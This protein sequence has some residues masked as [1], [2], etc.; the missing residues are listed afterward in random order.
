VTWLLRGR[1]RIH[2]TTVGPRLRGR[3]IAPVAH[4]MKLRKCVNEVVRRGR[5][6]WLDASE[7]AALAAT[8]G[9]ASTV[10]AIRDMSLR[11]IHHVLM[12]GLM[13]AGDLPPDDESRSSR[14]LAVW[15][16]SSMDWCARVDRA[17]PNSDALGDS[18]V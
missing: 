2:L 12:H 3:L 6:D 15:G 7:I 1:A 13:Q 11:I 14:A 8:V 18:L 4:T 9:Q 5:E 10:V 17:R 16:G